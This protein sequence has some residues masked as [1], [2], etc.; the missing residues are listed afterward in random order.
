[1]WSAVWARASLFRR[2][3]DTNVH[4]EPVP[5]KCGKLATKYPRIYGYFYSVQRMEATAATRRR[6]RCMMTYYD[7]P[8]KRRRPC[9]FLPRR[10]STR[11]R[12]VTDT[13]M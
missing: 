8:E 12:K 5:L 3:T 6:R 1:M 7:R 9:L 2:F 13:G 4:M 11:Q 10:L